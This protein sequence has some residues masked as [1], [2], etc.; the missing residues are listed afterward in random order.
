MHKTEWQ[1][2]LWQNSDAHV[3]TACNDFLL[4]PKL[5]MFGNVHRV[6]VLV[7]PVHIVYVQQHLWKKCTGHKMCISIFSSTI[8][9]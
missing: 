5:K 6:A 1:W 7:S 2:D 4:Y 9:V 3:Q 8:F